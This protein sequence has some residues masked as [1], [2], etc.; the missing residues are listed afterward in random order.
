MKKSH[1]LKETVVKYIDSRGPFKMR[2]SSSL[3]FGQFWN[4]ISDFCSTIFGQLLYVWTI[5]GQLLYVCPIK[6]F[7]ILIEISPK[8]LFVLLGY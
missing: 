3:P 2:S 8:M 1:F 7:C 4:V 5:F 6:V